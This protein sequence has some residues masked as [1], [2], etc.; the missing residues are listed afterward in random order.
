MLQKPLYLRYTKNIPDKGA[1]HIMAATEPIRDKKQLKSLANYFLKR[2][3]L[4]NH[5]L[6]V[7]R[8][9]TALR[10]S[11]LLRLKWSDV[12]DEERQDFRRHVTLTEKRPGKRL[13]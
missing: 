1:I 2:G 3:Q 6:I 8:T 4:R 10:I 13:P 11:N 9:C 12:Y 7:M 5:V